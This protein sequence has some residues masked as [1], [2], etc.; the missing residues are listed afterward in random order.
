MKRLFIIIAL[1]ALVGCANADKANDSLPLKEL[2]PK[3][4]TELTSEQWNVKKTLFKVLAENIA[5]ENGEFVLG[6][7]KKEFT[8][9]GLPASYYKEAKNS[10]K[11]MN[12][13]IKDMKRKNPDVEFDGE[14]LW[15]EAVKSTLDAVPEYAE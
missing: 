10:L 1:S 3:S 12:R 15:R 8:D 5:F 6:L 11:D 2:I 9:S 7:T 4:E 13:F 14:R